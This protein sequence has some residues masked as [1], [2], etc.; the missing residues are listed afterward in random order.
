MTSIFRHFLALLLVFASAPALAPVVAS[1]AG[2]SRCDR[3]G[4]GCCGGCCGHV[5]SPSKSC[6]DR[7][8]TSTEDRD[9]CEK[10]HGNCPCC[11]GLI[12][13]LAYLGVLSTVVVNA[14]PTGQLLL[15]CDRLESRSDQPLLP[16]PIA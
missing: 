8:P 10:D 16:P 6:C 14:Q 5:E 4:G 1:A 13:P 11:S 7:H 3:A 15:S 12:V 9:P 2:E